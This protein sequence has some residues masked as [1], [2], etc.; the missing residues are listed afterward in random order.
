MLEVLVTKHFDRYG[1]DIRI[2]SMMSDG[3]QSLVVISRVVE[4]CVTELA[5]DLTQPMLC[6]ERSGGTMKF[7]RTKPLGECSHQRL[8]HLPR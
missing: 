6:N 5:L 2:D 7:V 4:K 8:H 3:T 1:I